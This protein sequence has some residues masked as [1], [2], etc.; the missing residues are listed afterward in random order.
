MPVISRRDGR[1]P[2][3]GKMKIYLDGRLLD[4]EEARIP[5]TDRGVLFGDGLFETTV[6]TAASPSAWTG[7]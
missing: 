1:S 2:P 3:G 6:P 4:A 5:V 7:T